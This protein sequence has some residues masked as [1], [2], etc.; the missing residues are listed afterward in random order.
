MKQALCEAPLLSHPDFRKPFTIF[1]D[2]S[3]VGVGAVLT[4]EGQPIWFASRVLTPAE[5]KYDT[6]E[7]ECIGIMFGLEKFKPFYFG[8]HVTVFTDHGNLSWLMDHEQ[9][10]RLARWQLHLQ[11]FDFSINYVKG[12]HNPVADC[13]SRYEDRIHI[14]A[15]SLQNRR[16]LKEVAVP[17]TVKFPIKDWA[18]QQS[19]DPELVEIIKDPKTPF[20]LDS[21]IVYRKKDDKGKKRIVL[22]EHLVD[23]FIRK[24]HDSEEAAHGG[25]NKTSFHL[26]GVWFKSLRKRI[27]QHCKQCDICIRAKG[28]TNRYNELGTREPMDILEKCLLM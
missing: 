23:R 13:L 5:R 15:V 14:N 1:T 2:A 3:D 7:K 18:K 20:V 28:F 16:K 12:R 24:A 25:V 10:G 26:R 8:G 19:K 21:G 6:R 27:E 4:Q 22:P 17:R 9:K 11:K